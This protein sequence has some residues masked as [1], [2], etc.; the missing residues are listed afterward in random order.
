MSARLPRAFA[1]H[2]SPESADRNADSRQRR[3]AARRELLRAVRY[4]AAVLAVCGA[5]HAQKAPAF[6]VASVKPAGNI[7]PA[8]GNERIVAH[9]GSLT[10]SNVRLRTCIQ[11]AYDVRDYQISGP[12]SLGA[13]Y[14]YR[15]PPRYE[16]IAKARPDTPVGDLRLMLR[17]LIAERFK[18]TTHR[19]SREA[20][21]WILTLAGERHKLQPPSDPAGEF[22]ATP[23]PTDLT[24]QNSTLDEFAD[25]ISGPLRTP[26]LNRTGLA[27][28]FNF[29][30]VFSGYPV[31]SET[32]YLFSR[33]IREQLGLKIETRKAQIDMLIVDHIEKQPTEN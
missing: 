13:P 4:L 16:I 28:R 27:G 30:L 11:W 33:A 32:D 9:P 26:V 23:S 18:M 8:F 15:N 20:A 3:R 12:G 22:L 24:L 17:T 10:M 6:E 14:D 31:P 7:E 1:V 2:V 21:S 25:L 5:V 19:E 29:R